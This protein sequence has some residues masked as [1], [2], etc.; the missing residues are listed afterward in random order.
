MIF[1]CS[2]GCAL[3]FIGNMNNNYTMQVWGL[4]CIWI[5]NMLFSLYSFRKRIIFLFFNITMFTLLISRPFIAVIRNSNFWYFSPQDIA[6]SLNGV[7]ISLLFLFLGS[8]FASEITKKEFMKSN[9]INDSIKDKTFLQI[10]SFLFYIISISC[11]FLLNM[12]KFLYVK[13]TSYLDFHANF[14]SNMPFFIK[15]FSLF[16][17]FAMCCL[18]A[19]FPSKRKSIAILSMYIFSNIPTFLMGSRNSFVLS[20]IFSIVYFIMRSFYDTKNNWV[21]KKEGIL[22]GVLIPPGLIALGA[23]NYLRADE[24]VAPKGIFSL[25]VDFFYKQG[26]SFDTLSI[27]HKFMDRLPFSDIKLYTFGPY[28]DIFKY[29]VISQKL[30]GMRSMNEGN[31]YYRGMASYQFANNLDYVSRFKEFFQGN[32]FGSS[33]IL[34]TYIDFGYV[35]VAFFSFIFGMLS[36]LFLCYFRKNKPI[37]STIILV[38]LISFF[39]LPRDAAL[40]W[41]VFILKP[42][43]WITIFICWTGAFLLEKLKEEKIVRWLIT[44]FS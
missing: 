12:E 29:G 30:F 10:F 17:T 26:T 43:F 37:L 32:G 34:E 24:A 36:I 20:V 35:G 18:L 15:G 27:G 44:K 1:L 41:S 4:M 38:S 16:S 25:I 42:S 3:F 11:T 28:L 14:T 39:F 19:T 5:N 13:S 33:F 7:F 23:M 8:I 9:I 21:G 2:I 22:I 6:F 31:N 40:R